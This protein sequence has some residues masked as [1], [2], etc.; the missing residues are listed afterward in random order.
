MHL[1]I[2]VGKNRFRSECGA[3][4]GFNV[5]KITPGAGEMPEL[6]QDRRGLSN[7]QC[8][9]RNITDWHKDANVCSLSEILETGPVGHRY[10]L[11]PTACNGILRR[12]EKRGK[13]L[14][15]SLA[16]ALQAVASEQTSTSMAE[17][18]A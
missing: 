13:S 17:L 2:R 14:P 7:G 9:M 12:A 15:P 16:A 4:L 11:S 8:W 18:S 1:G 10:F 5:V 6:L 3:E